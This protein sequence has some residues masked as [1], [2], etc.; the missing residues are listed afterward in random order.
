[1]TGHTGRLQQ[2]IPQEENKHT[3]TETIL[4]NSPKVYKQKTLIMT[5]S[6]HFKGLVIKKK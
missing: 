4:T 6:L 5:T 1:M 3:N 2:E